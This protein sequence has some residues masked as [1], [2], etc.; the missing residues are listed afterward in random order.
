MVVLMS[1]YDVEDLPAAAADCGAVVIPAQGTP[2]SRLA[3]TDMA[4]RR[5]RFTSAAGSVPQWRAP[6]ILL[7]HGGPVFVIVVGPRPDPPLQ[8]G[9][10]SGIPQRAFRPVGER[11]RR[12]APPGVCV[13]VPTPCLLVF[14]A[15]G[16]P[17]CVALAVGLRLARLGRYQQSISLVCI[18]NWISAVAGDGYQPP[19]LPVMALV[20]LVPVV[21][22]EPYIRWQ[23]GWPSP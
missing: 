13:L 18:A 8:G 9:A 22:A 23:R 17:Q 6:K 14:A 21:F 2:E 15:V 10:L 7:S 4:S 5:L 16:A 19:L 1:T 12:A 3:E 20:A 11:R